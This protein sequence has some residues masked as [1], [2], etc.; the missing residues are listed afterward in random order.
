MNVNKQFAA[1]LSDDDG[2][3]S[4]SLPL[5]EIAYR[6]LY[7]SR[8]NLMLRDKE[9]A[10]VVLTCN[11]NSYLIKQ[12]LTGEELITRA[13][14]ELSLP[15]DWEMS[16]E[17][18]EARRHALSK[19]TSIMKYIKNLNIQ[20]RDRNKTISL[21]SKS[22]KSLQRTI[23][24]LDVNTDEDRATLI[25]NIGILMDFE[26][27]LNKLAKD[28]PEQTKTFKLAMTQLLAEE[29]MNKATM[30]GGEVSDSMDP[31]KSILTRHA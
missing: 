27:K 4:V 13:K 7:N 5:C 16:A 17:V 30:G 20:F 3:V 11:Y 15:L 31:T 9:L 8:A 22:I 14:R 28:V 10:F 23:S 18:K 29:N 26:D 21:I 25:T 12:G 1:I 2:K 24:G 6:K 19:Q